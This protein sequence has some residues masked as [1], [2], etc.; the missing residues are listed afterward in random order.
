MASNNTPVSPTQKADQEGIIDEVQVQEVSYFGANF[1]S[2]KGE[3]NSEA[4]SELPI[5]CLYFA[6]K[7]SPPCRIFTPVL[8]SF[9][10]EINLISKSFE[11]IYVPRDKDQESYATYLQQMPWISIP[12]DE[13]QRIIDFK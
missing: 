10:R 6:A 7:S 8:M 5:V 12:L 13:E 4:F 9:Y 1:S 3:V 2:K 11:I